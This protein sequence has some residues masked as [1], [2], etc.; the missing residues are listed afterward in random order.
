VTWTEV[1]QNLVN[2]YTAWNKPD[3]AAKWRKTLSEHQAATTAPS[4]GNNAT[5]ANDHP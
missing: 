1:L 2:L 5:K 3:E 4:T